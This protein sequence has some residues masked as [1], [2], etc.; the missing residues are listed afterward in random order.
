M[1]NLNKILLIG[2]SMTALVAVPAL[3]QTKK[4]A[5]KKATAPSASASAAS[6]PGSGAAVP[7][8]SA[9][10]TSTAGNST[11]GDDLVDGQTYAVRLRDLEQRVDALKEQIRRSHTKLSLLSDTVLSGSVAGSRT[12]IQFNNEMS[13]AFRVVRI[14]IVLDGAVQ[15]NKADDTGV[16]HD[17]RLIPIFSGSMPPGDHTLQVLV[18]LRGNGYGV[19]S[20][21]KGYKFDVR[22]THSF[23]ATEGKTLTLDV[24]AYEK[25]TVT[26][27]L[28]DR[29]N[30]RYLESVKSGIQGGSGA[31]AAK[32]PVSGSF[33]LSTGGSK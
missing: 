32:K 4:A 28:E 20:Y 18:Q 31:P 16:L 5:D 1:K 25:G 11:T 23:T 9:V 27:P 17:Q 30:I 12:D 14:L 33:N 24:T 6:P 3:A 29:P 13:N 2:L 7:A 8:S 22:S 15:Y 21:L 10:P 26:T 19:F